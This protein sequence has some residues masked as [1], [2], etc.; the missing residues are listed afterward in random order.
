MRSTVAIISVAAAG[1]I[2]LTVGTVMSPGGTALADPG[3]ADTVYA[4]APGATPTGPGGPGGPGPMKPGMRQG[5]PGMERGMPGMR[6]G[7]GP[8]MERGMGPGRHHRPDFKLKLARDLAGIE[9]MIGI[10]SDQLDAWRDFTS[11]L[12]ALIGPPMP[13]A[14]G[15]DD[16]P[17]AFA[18]PE[19]LAD[20]AIA[21]AET[22]QRLKAAIETLRQK[23]TPEQTTLLQDAVRRLMPPR[24]HPPGPGPQDQRSAPEAERPAPDAG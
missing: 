13:P 8:M 12:L 3:N 22:A 1:V 19:R 5:M 23:L 10:R 14:A 24:H 20:A 15:A 2:G 9:T 7:M 16:A 4:Q 21:K 17:D 11:T 18:L 6:H